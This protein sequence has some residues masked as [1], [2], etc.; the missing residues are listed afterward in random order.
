MVKRTITL[1]YERRVMGSSP[2]AGMG[3]SFNGRITGLHPVD[4]GSIPFV[5]IMPRSS[6]EE[7]WSYKPDAGGSIPSVA[8][9]LSNIGG[10]CA[11]LKSRKTRFDSEG[12]HTARSTSGKVIA[13]SRRLSRVRIPHALSGR[14][15]IAAIR[16]VSKTSNLGSSPSPG[17]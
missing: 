5:S 2:V 10:P 1:C 8:I 7:R 6:S 14:D 12:S 13:L 11:G 4:K 16:L 17:A 15:E 3:A 9:R